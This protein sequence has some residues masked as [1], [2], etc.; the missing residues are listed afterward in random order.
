MSDDGPDCPCDE[1]WTVTTAKLNA[2]DNVIAAA[3][4]AAL[5]PP[6]PGSESRKLFVVLDELWAVKCDLL[7][8]WRNI[9]RLQH[10]LDDVKA[11]AAATRKRL[12][13]P[14]RPLSEPG[15]L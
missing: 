3:V 12:D 15:A 14:T 7:E 2:H 6:A 9:T 8:A 4:A 13:G 1:C 11:G 10:E 5:P